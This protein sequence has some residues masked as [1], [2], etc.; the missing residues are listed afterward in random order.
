[1][2]RQDFLLLET[3]RSRRG[4]EAYRQYVTEP[5]RRDAP[6][7][8][9][10]FRNKQVKARRGNVSAIRDRGATQRC[11]VYKFKKTKNQRFL[12]DIR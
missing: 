1:M 6:P 10:G 9:F 7:R 3:S 8:L 12:G 5:Q 4:E 2:R 11:A